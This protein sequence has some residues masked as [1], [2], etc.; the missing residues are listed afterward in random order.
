MC[1]KHKSY[2]RKYK[3]RNRILN[4]LIIRFILLIHAL[5]T[6]LCY[7]VPVELVLH[8]FQDNIL[9]EEINSYFRLARELKKFS[10]YRY[11][12]YSYIF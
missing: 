10:F 8:I 11:P 5:E 2:N 6:C 4:E 3:K 1:T 12:F 9:W 7:C